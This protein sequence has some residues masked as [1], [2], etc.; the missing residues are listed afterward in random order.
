MIKDVISFSTH[1]H[2]YTHMYRN[3]YTY[4]SLLIYI[5]LNVKYKHN[6]LNGETVG[7]FIYCFCIFYFSKVYMY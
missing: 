4:I 6:F 1:T 3:V 7:D 2:M 5:Y